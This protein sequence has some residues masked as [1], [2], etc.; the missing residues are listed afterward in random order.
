MASHLAMNCR[1]TLGGGTL[2]HSS[3]YYRNSRSVA[4]SEVASKLFRSIMLANVGRQHPRLRATSFFQRMRSPSKPAHASTLRLGVY[5]A[6]STPAKYTYQNFMS[7]GE[8][9]NLTF[10]PVHCLTPGASVCVQVHGTSTGGDADEL[11]LLSTSKTFIN[12]RAYGGSLD[13]LSTKVT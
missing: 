10:P 9:I 1:R 2:S 11:R 7:V 3:L 12:L 13:F 6:T 4:Y 5:F 8:P